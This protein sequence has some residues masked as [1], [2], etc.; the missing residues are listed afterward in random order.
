MRDT[1]IRCIQFDGAP[2]AFNQNERAVFGEAHV[3][4]G[5]GVGNVDGVEMSLPFGENVTDVKNIE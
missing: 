1:R 4:G 3:I 2:F 5:V